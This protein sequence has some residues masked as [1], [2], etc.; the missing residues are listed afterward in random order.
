MVGF[1]GSLVSVGAPASVICQRP[2]QDRPSSDHDREVLAALGECVCDCAHTD[3][4][5]YP[6]GY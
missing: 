1:Y 3:I 4:R 6:G 2:L 5:W